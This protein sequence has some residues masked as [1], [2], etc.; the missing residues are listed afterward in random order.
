MIARLKGKLDQVLESQVILD[1]NGV[2]YAVEISAGDVARLP[3]LGGPLALEIH[4][5]I[6]EEIFDLYGFIDAIDRDLFRFLLSASGVGPK[7][8]LAALSQFSG[9][10]MLEIL[11]RED[12]H[13]LSSVPGIGKKK[14]EKIVLELRDRVAK[15]FGPAG[16]QERAATSVTA[17]SGKPRSWQ[18]DLFRALL[19]LGYRENEVKAA[20]EEALSAPKPPA[21]LEG[22]IRDCLRLLAHGGMKKGVVGHA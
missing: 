8:A 22:A 13:A 9:P 15:R 3:H 2:G 21:E 20:I 1:V 16:A 17:S 10:A 4:S 5:H 12:I 11:R 6:R 18:E 19:G 7:I 14:A